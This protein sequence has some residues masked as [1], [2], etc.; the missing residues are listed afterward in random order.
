MSF[1][2]LLSGLKII[3]KEKIITVQGANFNYLY[4]AM[5]KTYGSRLISNLFIKQG[6]FDFSF[7]EFY[8]LD[9]VF[10]IKSILTNKRGRSSGCTGICIKL[11]NEFR[12]IKLV[13]ENN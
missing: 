4:N 9:V 13:N 1:L 8:L 5:N 3:Q 11:L 2:S 6:R 12:N 7:H 10:I